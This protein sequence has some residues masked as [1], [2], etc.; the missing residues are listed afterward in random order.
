MTHRESNVTRSN[1]IAE[2][3]ARSFEQALEQQ[4]SLWEQVS[5]FARDE[6]YRFGSRQ[7]EHAGH[8]LEEL[9]GSQG[10]A[11]MMNAQQ[12]WLRKLTQDYA[13][14]S[15]RYSEMLRDLSGHAFAT[16]LDAGRRSM[17][18]GQEAMRAASD[19]AAQAADI[20]HHSGHAMAEAAGESA[21]EM[22]GRQADPYGNGHSHHA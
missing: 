6:S 21:S 7:L 9:H 4:R 3:L 17:M 15:I 14:Q 1:A 5:H 22:A 8:A 19:E 2:T 10:V 18:L 13:D 12:D 16:A 20:L 11:G